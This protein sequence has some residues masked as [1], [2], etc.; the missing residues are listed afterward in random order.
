MRF[1]R[2]REGKFPRGIMRAVCVQLFNI[3]AANPRGELR[4]LND[5]KIF[6]AF[7]HSFVYV[8][9]AAFPLN[10][11]F[12]ATERTAVVESCAVDPVRS[13]LN[14]ISFRRELQG[15]RVRPFLALISN[16]FEA[17]RAL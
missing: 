2:A 3:A 9:P 8:L 17:R 11:F 1:C 6:N 16:S 7:A 12:S 13:S 15:A 14:I 10:A 5:F 4:D